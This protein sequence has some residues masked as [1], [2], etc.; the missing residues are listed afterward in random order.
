MDHLFLVAT[1]RGYVT[2]ASGLQ[3]VR[4]TARQFRITAVRTIYTSALLGGYIAVSVQACTLG[5]VVGFHFH[6]VA[7]K[8]AP[9]Q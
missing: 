6:P 3:Q 8:A 7:L 5:E 1:P 9:P 4:A 2:D